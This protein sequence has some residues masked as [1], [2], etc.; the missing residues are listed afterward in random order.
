MVNGSTRATSS[1]SAGVRS[2]SAALRRSA[3]RASSRPARA[4]ALFR[5]CF[6]DAA[7]VPGVRR[8]NGGRRTRPHGPAEPRDCGIARQPLPGVDGGDAGVRRRPGGGVL[9]R[10]QRGGDRRRVAPQALE[11]IDD[12]IGAALLAAAAPPG[13]SGAGSRPGRRRRCRGRRGRG[14]AARTARPTGSP[15]DRAGGRRRCAPAAAAGAAHRGSRPRSRT[16]RPAS[17]AFSPASSGA[18]APWI[19]RP[20]PASRSAL[21]ARQLGEQLHALVR[22]APCSSRPAPRAAGPAGTAPA[23]ARARP[24]SGRCGSSLDLARKASP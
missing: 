8:Q 13:R 3:V 18:Q 4:R 9:G 2:A 1:R 19:S 14:A 15:R 10:L 12:R 24:A 16:P 6:I 7:R 11:G 23:A 5:I 20:M 17:S 21:G 22:L